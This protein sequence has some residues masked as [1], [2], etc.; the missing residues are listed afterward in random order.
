M[1]D[2]VYAGCFAGIKSADQTCTAFTWASKGDAPDESCWLC[3][4]CSRPYDTPES[5]ETFGVKPPS[6]CVRALATCSDISNQLNSP[7]DDETVAASG[8]EPG[9][10]VGQLTCAPFEPAQLTSGAPA[11]SHPALGLGLHLPSPCSHTSYT[12]HR[13]RSLKK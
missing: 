8:G 1:Q 2:A 4:Q 7:A 10:E 12:C 9:E 11:V 5:N 6:S 13:A 3:A